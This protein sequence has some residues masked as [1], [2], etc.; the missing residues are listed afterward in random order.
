MTNDT[1]SVGDSCL[2]YCAR[3]D[4]IPGKIVHVVNDYVGGPYY[5]V[6]IRGERF[7]VSADEIKARG[8]DHVVRS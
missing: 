2:V 8:D 3:R 1:L 7:V 4:W 6:E 5:T